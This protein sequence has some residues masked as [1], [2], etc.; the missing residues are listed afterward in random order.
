[1]F[2]PKEIVILMFIELHLHLLVSQL[3]E[4]RLTIP[5]SD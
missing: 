3:K 2:K 5:E 4:F 1:M